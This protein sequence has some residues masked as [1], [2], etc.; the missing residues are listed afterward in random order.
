MAIFHPVEQGSGEWFAARCGIPT[1]SQ[2]HK[3][4]TPTGELSTTARTYAHYLVAEALLGRSLET[5]S[6]LEWIARGR[7]LEP[8]AGRMYELREEVDCGPGG[9]FTTDDGRIGA[10]PD[11]LLA[12]G[13]AGLEIKCPSPQVHIGYLLGDLGDHYRPQVQGQLWVCEFEY[14]DLWSYHPEMPPALVRTHRDEA[15]IGKLAA[16]L[17]EFCDHLDA[18]R[19]RAR[20]LGLF[21]APKRVLTPTDQMIP[22]RGPE[23]F[24]LP[25]LPGFDAP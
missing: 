21:A 4:I 1:A 6:A 7:E 23:A 17:T 5:E 25:G 10:S 13:R 16:A 9:F 12:G 8:E 11:R 15:F 22:R 18:L 20:A 24:G 2:F 19:E 3:I 14:V